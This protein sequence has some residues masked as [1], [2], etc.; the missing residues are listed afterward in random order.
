MKLVMKTLQQLLMKKKTNLT[1]IT[2][3]KKTLERW[4]LKEVI[5]KKTIWLKRVKEKPLIKLLDKINKYK[6]MLSYCLKCRKSRENINQK[7]SNNYI[8]KLCYMWQ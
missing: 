8:I 5:L 4:K 3:L 2:N 7:I 1:K 6:T